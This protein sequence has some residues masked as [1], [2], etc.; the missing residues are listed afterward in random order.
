[1]DTPQQ[2]PLVATRKN[3]QPDPPR[4]HVMARAMRRLRRALSGAC[5]RT[6][7][8]LAHANY[9]RRLLATRKR[10]PG[11]TIRT[12]DLYNRHGRHGMLAAL[13]DHCGP[14]ATVYDVGASV[15]VYALSLTADAPDRRVVA[16]EPAP[17]TAARLRANVAATEP[18]GGL[19]VRPV[20]LGETVGEQPFYVST[21]PEL[22]G[23]DP[24]SATRWGGLV[25]SVATVEQCRL[26]DEVGHRRPDGTVRPPPDVLKLDVEGAEADVIRGGR[27]TIRRHR[28]TLF[29]EV[30]EEGLSDSP[31]ERLQAEL[32]ALGYRIETY[33]SYWRCEPVDPADEPASQC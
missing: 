8:L 22:S 33:G 2:P 26:D 25:S 17:P 15:G 16:Y 20:G 31:A 29:V 6:Y 11:G 1:M 28:P 21:L 32:C 24:E 4:N 19:E 9:D 23:F 18:A 3:H 7:F 5:Y 10:T 13:L 14:T 30:H 27:E 12:Y